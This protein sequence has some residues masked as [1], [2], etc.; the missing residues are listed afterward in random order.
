MSSYPIIQISHIPTHTQMEDH[1]MD[2]AMN[3]GMGYNESKIAPISGPNMDEYYVD[4]HDAAAGNL[5]KMRT[6]ARYRLLGKSLDSV[7][8]LDPT[9]ASV[10]GMHAR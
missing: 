3:S 6:N 2:I 8:R 10:P 5:A 9:Y 1:Y 4:H 7:S